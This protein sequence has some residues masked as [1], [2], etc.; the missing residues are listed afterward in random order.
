MSFADESAKAS[1]V[2]SLAVPFYNEA[3]GM[4]A[5]FDRVEGVLAKV[6][7]SYEI[8]CVNDGSRDSTLADLERERARDPRIRVVNLTRNFGKEAALAA[9]LDH[10]RGEAIIPMDA[11]LQDPPELV[12]QMVAHWREGY[13]VVVARRR[14]RQGDGWFKKTSAHG[15]YRLFNRMSETAIPADVGDFR[16]IDRR[17]LGALQQLKE[18]N[19]FTKG[20]FAW[21]G[22]RTKEVW[23]DREPREAGTSK[24]NYWKLWNFAL[25]GIFAF[26]TTPLRIWTYLGATIASG[27]FAYA[28]FIIGR[29][30]IF[31][32]DPA[33]PGYASLIVVILFLGGIQL[34]S[35][36]VLGEYIGRI[37]KETKGRPIYLVDRELD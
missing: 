14:R 34:I 2:L 16:L 21:V 6:E 20:L 18:R 19:R 4:R 10:C 11:D 9:A 1:P 15:F 35:L 7:A 12:V 29:T 37:F 28:A 17:V 5:F 27:A 13:P 32:R 31:G 26:S 8:V 24:W 36:G 25:D 22:F 3:D 33:A 23:F 30:L